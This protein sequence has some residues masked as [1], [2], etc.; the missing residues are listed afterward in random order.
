MTAQ[1]AP[2]SLS[3]RSGKLYAATLQ[4]F[5]LSPSEERLL[6]EGLRALDRADEASAI[7][8]KLGLIVEDRYGCPK[9]NP[10]AE[11][12]LRSRALFA[13]CLQQL[14][15]KAS[16]VAVRP[17]LRNVGGRPANVAP[18]RVG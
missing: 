1:K 16:L 11:I 8:A 5:E 14:G 12:E 10:A 17:R 2:S 3:T 15:T 7:V 13:R 9:T 18:R 6:E 4:E